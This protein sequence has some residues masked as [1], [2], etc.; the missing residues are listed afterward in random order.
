LGTNFIN[1]TGSLEALIQGL[2][3][4]N[5]VIYATG[6]FQRVG[7]NAALHVARWDGNQWA[8][9]GA[10]INPPN[11]SSSL[12]LALL[13]NDL[14]VGT[15]CNLGTNRI[16]RWNGS[17]WSTF[18]GTF[19]KSDGSSVWLLKILVVGNQ[20]YVGGRF[21]HVDGVE[22][23]GLAQ[24]DGNQWRA[25]GSGLGG[26]VYDLALREG[27]VYAVGDFTR[28]G[29]D[30]SSRFAIWNQGVNAVPRLSITFATTGFLLAWP[31]SFSNV[32]V[33]STPS[34]GV[35]DWQQA[36][37][38]PRVENGENLFEVMPAGG[39]GFYRLKSP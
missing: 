27:K 14:L 13:G 4:T 9:L 15:L 33:E 1:D 22:V 38:T 36:S 24:W 2:V 18:P 16:L 12:E 10:G 8:G 28:A 26:V 20:L 39:A 30:G 35:P 5:D 25:F 23:N 19:T 11:F 7:T 21:S 37:G 17:G 29:I 6:Y 34:L 32:V 31:E 3:V